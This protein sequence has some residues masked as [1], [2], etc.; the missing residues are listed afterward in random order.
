[1]RDDEHP[2]SDFSEW[3]KDRWWHHYIRGIWKDTWESIKD[4]LIGL[5]WIVLFPLRI[6]I[7][8]LHLLVEF[9]TRLIIAIYKR[10]RR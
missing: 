10:C 6:T 1:M 2:F 9:I 4:L 3:I 7:Q 8:V 5:F